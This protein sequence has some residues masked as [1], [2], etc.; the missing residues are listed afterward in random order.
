MYNIYFDFSFPT[1]HTHEFTATN[2]CFTNF[3]YTY[4][5]VTNYDFDEL[6]FPRKNSINNKSDLT[7]DL[8]YK[9]DYNIYNYADRLFRIYSKKSK[10]N[11]G[12]I[13]FEHV[14]FVDHTEDFINKIMKPF[15][16]NSTSRL[17]GLVQGNN[18]LKLSIKKKNYNQEIVSKSISTINCLNKTINKI[19]MLKKW[20]KPYGFLINS[21]YGKSIYNT[22]FTEII[23][24]HY[25]DLLEKN[26]TWIRLSINEGFSSHFRIFT[27]NVFILLEKYE[28][29]TDFIIDSE[30]SYFLANHVLNHY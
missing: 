30:Y 25:V 10:K 9:S 3:K 14:L 12:T 26:A 23:N 1:F 16:G 7:C 19:N 17:I 20:N 21:R 27:N 8:S 4:E 5:F 28:F 29:K 13:H 11:I 15:I 6:I 2:D 18:I 24:Q 22:N